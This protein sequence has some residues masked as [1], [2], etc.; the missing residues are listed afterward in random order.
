MSSITCGKVQNIPLRYFFRNQM[1]AVTKFIGDSTKKSP[2]LVIHSRFKP[3]RIDREDSEASVMSNIRSGSRG[4]HRSLDPG[5]SKLTLKNEG[6]CLYA[7]ECW[8]S[9][10]YA[11]RDKSGY[12]KS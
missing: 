12:L 4:L 6:L 3:R 2:C 5:S 8:V 1:M 11:M 7:F 9:A 10:L